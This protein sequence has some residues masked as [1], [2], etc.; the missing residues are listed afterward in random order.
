LCSRHGDLSRR[1]LVGPN[2][3]GWLCGSGCLRLRFQTDVL[4]PDYVFHYMGHPA[5]TS[6][7]NQ[8]ASG[9]TLIHINC[10]A[11]QSMP[12]VAPP[13]SQQRTIA[14]VLNAIKRK[15]ELNDE[16]NETL[17]E[18]ARGFFRA[19]IG[20]WKIGT[21]LPRAVSERGARLGMVSELCERIE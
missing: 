18:L 3:D 4:D 8:R 19:Q 21:E 13:L 11:R 16:I 14:A 5:V 20:N 7:L 2:E 15:M 6:W 10:A 9:S 1:A 17:F 12:I